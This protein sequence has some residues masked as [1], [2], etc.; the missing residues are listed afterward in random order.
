[1]TFRSSFDSIQLLFALPLATVQTDQ[2]GD[3]LPEQ[4][5]ASD[6]GFKHPR[7]ST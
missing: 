3:D 5:H 4:G 2:A 6:S 7:D 1:L